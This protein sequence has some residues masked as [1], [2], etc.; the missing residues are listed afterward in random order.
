MK[1][2]NLIVSSDALRPALNYIQVIN[3]HC[4]ATNCHALVK[5]PNSEVFGPDIILPN[6]EMY[7]SGDQWKKQNFGKAIRIIRE[8]NIFK[9]YDRKGVLIGM[10]ESIDGIK[11]KNEV[12]RFPDCEQVVPTNELDNINKIS[13]SHKYYFDIIECFN[14]ETPLF[15]MEFRGETRCIIIKTN[16]H[17]ESEGFGLLMPIAIG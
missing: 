5:I 17:E 15:H 14:L 8:T 7:F 13:F 12:G 11:F 2:L 10:I 9:A 6:E 3:G 4:Y 1:K 16:I